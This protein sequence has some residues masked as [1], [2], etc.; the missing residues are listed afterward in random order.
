MLIEFDNNLYKS[1]IK[2]ANAE[3]KNLKSLIIELL[4]DYTFDDKEEANKVANK[5]E[6]LTDG[7]EYEQRKHTI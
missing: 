4:Q 3:G 6:I 1:A 5:E 2:K 7:T